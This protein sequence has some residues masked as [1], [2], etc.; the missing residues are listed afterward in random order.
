MGPVPAAGSG[1]ETIIA[2]NTDEKAPIFG[3]ADY[4]IIGDCVELVKAYMR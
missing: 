2:V 4:T 3:V 1:A